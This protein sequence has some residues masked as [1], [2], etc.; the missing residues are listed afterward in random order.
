MLPTVPVAAADGSIA[1][2]DKWEGASRGLVHPKGA[3]D[4]AATARTY[5]SL[6]IIPK[7]AVGTAEAPATLK[8][9]LKNIPFTDKITLDPPAMPAQIEQ[10]ILPRAITPVGSR[11]FS[12]IASGGVKQFDLGAIDEST[13]E[14]T[15]CSARLDNLL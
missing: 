4:C 15:G 7:R 11:Y 14:P 8:F 9:D 10:P 5:V 13:G 12:G 6:T 2:I 1:P 3:T